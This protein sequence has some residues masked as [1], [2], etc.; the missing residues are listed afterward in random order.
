MVAAGAVGLGVASAAS[1]SGNGTVSGCYRP[2]GA[3]RIVGKG[4]D[5]KARESRLTWNKRGRQGAVGPVGPQ[6]QQG[7]QG[8]PG[9][10]GLAFRSLDWPDRS[11][12]GDVAISWAAPCAP[13]ESAIGGGYSLNVT[14]ELLATQFEVISSLPTQ[15]RP[16]TEERSYWVI[17]LRRATDA[18]FT[19]PDGTVYVVCVRTP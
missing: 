16:G 2:D 10:A 11:S 7:L 12:V 5:C 1:T 14:S 6:G 19:W 18:E 15:A 4:E 8:V 13:G 3:L 17:S 9:L